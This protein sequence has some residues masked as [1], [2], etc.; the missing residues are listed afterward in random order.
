MPEHYFLS[1]PIAAAAIQRL[2]SAVAGGTQFLQ[3][4]RGENQSSAMAPCCD[5]PLAAQATPSAHGLRSKAAQAPQRA[6]PVGRNEFVTSISSSAGEKRLASWPD[7]GRSCCSLVTSRRSFALHEGLKGMAQ[8]RS[9]GPVE[10]ALVGDLTE[11]K[12]K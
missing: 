10:I 3:V 7:S 2:D 8:P 9:E 1:A 12:P 11:V 6:D 5:N 4:A